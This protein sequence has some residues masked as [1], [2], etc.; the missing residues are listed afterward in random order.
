MSE[1]GA[2]ESRRNKSDTAD[3][4]CISAIRNASNDSL[5]VEAIPGTTPQDKERY[6]ATREISDVSVDVNPNTVQDTSL[7]IEKILDHPVVR[8]RP[9]LDDHI[10]TD[11]PIS[12]VQ[13]SQ[14]SSSI[15]DKECTD[16]KPDMTNVQLLEYWINI[17]D[18]TDPESQSVLKI[19]KQS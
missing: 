6:A 5:G 17:H 1:T 8:T 7:N 14:T 11:T 10:F 13:D 3:I 19:L 18:L 9:T 2:L 4:W 16:A 15:P 12:D